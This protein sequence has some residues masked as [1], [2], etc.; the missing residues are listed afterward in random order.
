[1]AS[2][3]RARL[4]L[5]EPLF[6]FL[7]LGLGLFLL[8]GWTTLAGG[9]TG[10]H[11]VI[12]QGRIEQLATGFALM[13]QRPPDTAELSGLID[14][15]I[16]EEVFYREARAMGLDQDDT[17][18]RRRLRQKLEFVSED[19]ARAPEPTDAQLQ[20]Y[21]QA[22]LDEFRLETRYTFTQVYLDPQ[23]HE[24]QLEADVRQALSA[25]QRGE[26]TTNADKFG[27]AFLLDH[28]FDAITAGELTRVFG[29][30]FEVALRAVPTGQ[31]LGPITSGFGV[32]LVLVSRRDE[33]RTASL[34]DVRG[35]VRRQWLHAQRGEANE[36]F[37]ADLRKRYQVTVNRSPKS[38]AGAAPLVAEMKQ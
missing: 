34:D 13:N 15:A 23:R 28:H 35:E 38:D 12:T 29:A 4:V 16:R 7:V 14:D 19:V 1:M 31:W 5:R 11:I 36:R 2:F 20:A 8:H 32:H 37:Y 3:S 10:Q 33:S 21:L 18:V 25:L 26:T 27:D 30:K 24:K 22:H 6:H 17:I 9:G